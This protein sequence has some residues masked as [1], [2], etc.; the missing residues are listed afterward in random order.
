[1]SM[2]KCPGCNLDVRASAQYCE[3]CAAKF[4][5]LTL[6]VDSGNLLKNEA[7]DPWIGR[8]VGLKY[9]LLEKLGEG[10]IGVVYRA[11]RNDIALEVAIKL[12]HS[13]HSSDKKFIERFKREAEAAG[14]IR[15]PNVVTIHDFNEGDVNSP[16]FIAMELISGDPLDAI[17]K[18]D[19]RL[20]PQRVISLMREICRG[21]G[22]GHKLGIVH[23]DL[24]PANIMIVHSDEEDQPE[25]IKVLDFGLAKLLDVDVRHALTQVGTVMGTP[26]YMS[27]E[28]CLGEQLDLRSDVYSLGILFYEM[29][30][31]QRPF[32]GTDFGAIKRQHINAVPPTLTVDPGLDTKLTGIIMRSLS[33]EREKR[34]ENASVLGRQLKELEIFPPAVVATTK[35]KSV[36]AVGHVG[37]G[38]K[39]V[40]AKLDPVDRLAKTLAEKVDFRK[41]RAAWRKS[42]FARNDSHREVLALFCEL[43]TRGRRVSDQGIELHTSANAGACSIRFRSLVLLASWK[44]GSVNR[45]DESELTIELRSV[46]LLVGERRTIRIERYDVDM[47]PD[48][49]IGWCERKGSKQVLSSAKIA[50]MWFQTFLKEIERELSVD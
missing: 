21:V 45:L 41:K 40:D 27:P 17:L 31:G 39:V 13:E 50:D 4:E 29:L 36:P 18:N 47:G 23:R 44:P 7:G 24:K 20:T 26:F 28:Q 25:R 43:M 48:L 35:L 9:E 34:Q 19:V 33:K 3:S 2:R 46:N 12:L 16:A 30:T 49:S 5:A 38:E 10:N 22:A 42:E 14:R 8:T 1:M 11:R 32:E 15:H 6:I 37:S